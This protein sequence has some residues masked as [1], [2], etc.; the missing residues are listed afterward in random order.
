MAKDGFF[1]DLAR[2]LVDGTLTRGKALRLMGAA[3]VGG[4]LGSLGMGEASADECKRNGK[5]CKKDKQCCSGK[6]E[7]NICVAACPSGQV[8]CGGNCVSNRCLTGQTFNT[9]TCQC[10]CPSGQEV[11][12]GSC[13]S[14]SCPTGQTLNTSTCQCEAV[15]CVEGTTTGCGTC[16]SN[17]PGAGNRAC[18]CQNLPGGT[19]QI[20]YYG[21][22]CCFDSCAACADYPGSVC[23]E[24]TGAPP[25]TPF[26]C[27]YP[28]VNGAPCGGGY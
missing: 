1:D 23:V 3:L 19:G 20:C 22:V 4:T 2:G 13:V 26:A 11:C 9:T 25:G 7:G 16:V 15:V 14:S 21:S 8:L 18:I 24:P 12:G 28:C 27:V 6:C 5:A 17:E 10:E